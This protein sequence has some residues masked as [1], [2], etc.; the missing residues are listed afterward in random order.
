MRRVTTEK[1]ARGMVVGERLM[2]MFILVILVLLT[3]CV[4]QDKNYNVTS[5]PSV[6]NEEVKEKIRRSLIGTS[7]AYN[8]IA[9]RPVK[10]N[11]SEKD[12]KSIEKIMLDGRNV[13]K[14]RIGDGLAWDYYYNE[15]G[16]EIIKKEQLFVT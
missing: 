5:T 13:W 1:K 9:G 4:S 10:Y 15:Q 16:N 11:V 7:I 2:I 3:G 8:D 14:V 12:I 6:A